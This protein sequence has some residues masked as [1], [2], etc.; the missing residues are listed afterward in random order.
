MSNNQGVK[1]SQFKSRSFS[2]EIPRET[3]TAERS[4]KSV[5]ADD[6]QDS[7]IKKSP[8]ATSMKRNLDKAPVPDGKG[9]LCADGRVDCLITD[10]NPILDHH[11][12]RA[13]EHGGMKGGQDLKHLGNVSYGKKGKGYTGYMNDD[14]SVR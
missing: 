4:D 13:D 1:G 7:I 12:N 9:R 5:R 14:D 2:R 6:T 3:N 11:M 10:K 8:W